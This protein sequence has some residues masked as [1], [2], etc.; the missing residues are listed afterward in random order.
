VRDEKHPTAALVT[1]LRKNLEW[2]GRHEAIVSPTTRVAI[3]DHYGSSVHDATD[4]IAHVRRRKASLETLA[5]LE[6]SREYRP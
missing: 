4:D 2:T 3:R 1:K 5:S 6:S